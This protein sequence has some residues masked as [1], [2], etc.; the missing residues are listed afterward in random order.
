[1]MP[2]NKSSP[3]RSRRRKLWRISCLTGL[4]THPLARRAFRVE[5]RTGEGILDT[6]PADSDGRATKRPG[7][8]YQCR[9]TGPPEAIA[10]S[11][12]PAVRLRRRGRRLD[13]RERLE[14]P[15]GVLRPF[16]HHPGVALF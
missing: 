2:G 15:V 7:P 6:A 13:R 14:D 5:G 16:G 4:D 12:V 1:M 10:G 11:L 3:P 9:G 8:T